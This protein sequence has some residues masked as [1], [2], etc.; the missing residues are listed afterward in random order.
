LI[1]AYDGTPTTFGIGFRD[2]LL[3]IDSSET[4]GNTK[5]DSGS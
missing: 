5:P 2:H 4:E 3:A 1:T